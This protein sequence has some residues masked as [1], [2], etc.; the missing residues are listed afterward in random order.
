MTNASLRYTLLFASALQVFGAGHDVSRLLERAIQTRDAGALGAR[1]SAIGRL[2][3]AAR[4]ALLDRFDRLRGEL[5]L[6]A[7]AA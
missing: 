1:E 6:V 7:R 3:E 2:N 4:Q 5:P